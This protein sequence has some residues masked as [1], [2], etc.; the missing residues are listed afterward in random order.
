MTRSALPSRPN[1][2]LITADQWRGD[3]V[4]YA[5]HPLVKTPHMDALANESATFSRHYATSS[6]CGPARASLYTGLYQMNNRVIANGTPLDHRF[7]NIA[8]AARRAGYTPTLFGYTDVAADPNVHDADDPALRT[9]EG[10][11]PGFDVEQAL[12]GDRLPWKQWLRNRGHKITDA[13]N[14]YAL[15]KDPKNRIPINGAKFTADETQTA[16]L[17]GRFIEWLDLQSMQ[18]PWFAHLSLLHPHPP[19]VAPEPY[20][21]MYPPDNV[22]AFRQAN[23]ELSG[24]PVVKLTRDQHG[25]S[26]FVPEVPGEVD[27]LTDEDFRQIGAIYYGLISEVDAQIG[28]LV[29]ALKNQGH[30]E[31]TVLI[32]TSD[33]GEMMGDF[34]LLGK[35]GFFEQSQHIPL[36]IR[37]PDCN[38]ACRCEHFTSSV[39]IFPTILELIDKQPMTGMDGQS[40]IPFVRGTPPKTWREAALWEFDFRNQTK[41]CPARRKSDWYRSQ[42]LLVRRCEKYLL[43]HSPSTPCLLFDLVNDP[44]CTRNLMEKAEYSALRIHLSE[45]LLHERM[46]LASDHLTTL[47]V[48]QDGVTQLNKDN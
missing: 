41:L 15:P 20:N 29:A 1:I 12:L 42:H 9:Y 43:M 47:R 24:H 17:T 28:R 22:P 19:F 36:L 21:T 32:I 18:R 27:E 30:W 37:L 6:P 46:A 39:D 45:K 26:A 38:K 35:G 3:C 48:G 11:L 8:R 14:P 33:H 2:L 34:G 5:G 44:N 31:N 40:L 23:A 16:Y 4:G 7:D 10:V 25:I 13:D